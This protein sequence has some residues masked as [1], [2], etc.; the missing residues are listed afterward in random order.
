M[1]RKH[2]KGWLKHGDFIVLDILCLQLCFILGFWLIRGFSNPYE[3]ESYQFQAIVLIVSQ[4][5]VVLFANNYGGIR[6]VLMNCCPSS[7]T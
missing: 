2:L 6:S 3:I 7:S 5:V 4:L 1:N